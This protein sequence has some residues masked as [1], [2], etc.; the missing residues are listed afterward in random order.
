MGFT[1]CWDAWE[2]YVGD[3]AN[4]LMCGRDSLRRTK[5]K[6]VYYPSNLTYY[7]MFNLLKVIRSY[8]PFHYLNK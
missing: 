3:R 8:T 2:A 7:V 5:K 1:V 4:Y 6:R